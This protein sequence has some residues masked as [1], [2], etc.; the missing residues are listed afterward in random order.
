MDLVTAWNELGAPRSPEDTVRLQA[1][2]VIHAELVQLAGNLGG[3][4]AD[5]LPS[6]TLLALLRRRRPRLASAAQVRAYL[7]RALLNQASDLR[8]AEEIRRRHELGRGGGE[9]SSGGPGTGEVDVQA[10]LD[11]L[12]DLA[13]GVAAGR[14]ER[15]GARF[16]MEF[17]ELVDLTVLR[18]L[19]MNELVTA[20]LRDEGGSEKQAR[21]RVHQRHRRV[22]RGLLETLEERRRE[23]LAADDLAEFQRLELLALLVG[24]LYARA[25][26]GPVSQQDRA[27]H[28]GGTGGPRGSST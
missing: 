2:G 9:T 20:S 6:L 5:D 1:L 10:W 15:Q 28:R 7:W 13:R 14:R 21:D 23:A 11:A 22:R 8:R 25:G 27:R 19:R 3:G 4:E 26:P 12:D 24:H 16:L 18:K 17:H